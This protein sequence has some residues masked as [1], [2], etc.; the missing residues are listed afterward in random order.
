MRYTNA[1]YDSPTSRRYRVREGIVL[2]RHSLPN[3]NLIVTLLSVTG[4]WQASVQKS[5]RP[6]GNV[7]KLSLFHDVTVQY[8]QKNDDML[9]YIIQVQLNGALPR[10]SLPDIYPYAH[11][12]T[13]LSERLSVDAPA[14]SLHS[15]LASALRG[16][17]EHHDP[18][19]VALLMSWRLLQQAGFAPRLK[20]C[21]RCTAALSTKTSTDAPADIAAENALYFDVA[22]GGMVCASCR[23]GTLLPPLA[24]A[25]L[26]GM[27]LRPVRESLQAELH[28]MAWHWRLLRH[29]VN[30][31][32][33]EIESLR[34]YPPEARG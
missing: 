11:I 25:E 6:G 26:Q 29:Y 13:E 8:Y 27:L 19:L 2:R 17:S 14:E 5:R 16:L 24:Y 22:A 18:G 4:K 28:D 20:R 10:L 12:V 1:V 30:Y 9:P 3:G 7:G 31:H 23:T 15:Y 32:V 21:V 34:A 33:G